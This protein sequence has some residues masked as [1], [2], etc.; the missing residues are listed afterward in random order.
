MTVSERLFAVRQIEHDNGDTTWVPVDLDTFAE[1][2]QFQVFNTFTGLH[3]YYGDL[4]SAKARWNELKQ[5]IVD[6]YT[7]V[8]PMVMVINTEA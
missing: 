2:D 1:D 4:V 7:P 5:Q 3:E 6:A 8:G